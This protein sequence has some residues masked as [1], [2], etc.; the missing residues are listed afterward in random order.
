ML[1]R[2]NILQSMRVVF[3]SGDSEG[4]WTTGG[5]M[6]GDR[7]DVYYYVGKLH[8]FFFIF[9]FIQLPPQVAKR[10]DRWSIGGVKYSPS[11]L[12]LVLFFFWV[13][14]RFF[15]SG[16]CARLWKGKGNLFSESHWFDLVSLRFY[17]IYLPSFFTKIEK[18]NY[19]FLFIP[20]CSFYLF[21]YNK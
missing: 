9:F 7:V 10:G 21:D 18:K 3:N 5:Q 1:D 19:F 6:W 20:S 17:F 11:Q 14:G 4:L 8:F 16:S 12:S 2:L 15:S 13:K